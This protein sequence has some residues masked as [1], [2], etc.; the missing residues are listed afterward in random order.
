MPSVLLVDDEPVLVRAL[1]QY[2]MRA[3]P[4]GWLV[5]S[6]S[7]PLHALD[8]ILD[9]IAHDICVCVIDLNLPGISGIELIRRVQ[10]ARPD[11]HRRFILCTGEPL[12]EEDPLLLELGCEQL[13]KPF[14]LADLQ[15]AVLR[16]ASN[17]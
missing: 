12:P 5:L 3:L 15:A 14:E 1:A 8:Q 6:E 7:S 4:E 9:D 13:E 17:A 16:V 11:L 10:R 2:L